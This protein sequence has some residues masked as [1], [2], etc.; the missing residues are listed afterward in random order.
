MNW[1]NDNTLTFNHDFSDGQ[2]INLVADISEQQQL[3]DRW[4]FDA[5]QYADNSI[6]TINGAAQVVVN[7]T[8]GSDGQP[9]TAAQTW[10]LV[11]YLARLNY[12]YKQRYLLTASVRRDG[13]SRFGQNNRWG[14]FPSLALGWRISNE[15]WMKKTSSW[16]SNLKLRFAYGITGNNQIGNFTY[17]SQLQPN[18]YVFGGSLAAGKTLTSMSNPNLA[19]E[20]TNEINLGLNVGFLNNRITVT[21]DAYRQRTKD[22]LLNLQVPEASGFTSTIKNIGE[23]QN[24]GF[25][26]DVSTQNVVKHDFT[27]SSHFIFSLNRNK[28][29]ALGPDGAPIYAGTSGERHPTNVT[30]VGKPVGLF[31]GYKFLGLYTQA[32]INNPN[33]AKF[34][35]AIPGN[36]RVEDVNKDGKISPLKDFTIIGNPYPKFDYGIT[37]TLNYKGLSLNFVFTG[38]YGAQRMKA[39]YE[40]L[41][42][43]DGIF[44]VPVEYAMNRYRSPSQPGDGRHPT[45][46]GSAYGRV[47]YRDTNS[48]NVFDASY[49]W[50]KNITLGYTLPNSITKGYFSSVLLY[51]SIQNAFIITPYPNGNP[52]VTNY[53][54]S[55]GYGGSLSPGV[56][57]TPYP[58]PRV[59]TV[60]FKIN[61]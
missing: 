55:Q 43:I 20:K 36:M 8:L 19:W 31:Y 12:S 58:T 38:S 16:L 11:S 30:E 27:W 21:A 32:D 6:R 23:V 52:A 49:L 46:S 24:K 44:N 50:C 10:T 54:G 57:F 2:N 51:T 60:G 35:G 26:L 25:E 56:D 15:P 45:T 13:S 40:T 5:S 22:L 4:R 41:H 34:S 29:L 48:L 1:N 3:D 39:N 37:N 53:T 47:M 33:I 59:I 14:T 9:N 17:E 28:V 42:N 18:N 61:Y 7:S